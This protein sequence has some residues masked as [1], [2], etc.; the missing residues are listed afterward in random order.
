MRDLTRM[1]EFVEKDKRMVLHS[2]Y[3]VN[4]HVHYGIFKLGFVLFAL[5]ESLFYGFAKNRSNIK[6]YRIVE[7]SFY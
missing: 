1:H 2:T 3:L 4:G 7:Q 5:L 6:S